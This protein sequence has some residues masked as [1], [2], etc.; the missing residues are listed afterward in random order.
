MKWSQ[1][2][3][4]Y[5][6]WPAIALVVWGELT[7]ADSTLETHIWDKFLHFTAYFG[8]AGIATVGFGA[9]KTAVWALLGLIALGGT[10][11]ILQGLT[12]RDMSIYDELT[13]TLGVLTGG[14]AGWLL[15]TVLR[16]KPIDQL[17]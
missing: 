5:L 7:P 14:F 15:I 9:R 4:L 13:N 2:L 3:A 10:L 1:T 8:M 12:G 17:R 16:P 6:F 11:E